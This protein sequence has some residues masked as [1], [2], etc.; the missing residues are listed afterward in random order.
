MEAIAKL[1][2]APGFILIIPGLVVDLRQQ[3]LLLIHSEEV[4]Q[5]GQSRNQFRLFS[6]QSILCCHVSKGCG[7]Q[8]CIHFQGLGLCDAKRNHIGSY[9]RFQ[10]ICLGDP[11]TMKL[12]FGRPKQ[13]AGK[14]PRTDIRAGFH[15]C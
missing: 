5:I 6:A 11:G 15:G 7:S 2:G 13:V 4:F 8:G 9:S 10:S 14:A 12:T 3:C 1:L